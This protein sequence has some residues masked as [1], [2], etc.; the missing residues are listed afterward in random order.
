MHGRWFVSLGATLL[1]TLSRSLVADAEARWPIDQTERPPDRSIEGMNDP[2]LIA[3]PNM[4]VLVSMRGR[5]AKYVVADLKA[6]AAHQAM[7]CQD[8][9]RGSLY[10]TCQFDGKMYNAIDVTDDGGDNLRI[11]FY[12][13]GDPGEDNSWATR[14][15]T[16]KAVV[17][18]IAHDLK[19][20]GKVRQL[21]RCEF[22]HS[23][24]KSLWNAP[25]GR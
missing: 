15:A 23:N 12:I 21:E 2:E 10:L 3:N 8:P 6:A 20:S 25:S 18:Q 9:D 5:Y 24:C 14:E 7:T 19:H 4:S 13:L 1:L 17:R 22:P 16:V 11:D